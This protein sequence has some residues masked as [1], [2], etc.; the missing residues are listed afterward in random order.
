MAEVEASGRGRGGGGGGGGGGGEGEREG[1]EKTRKGGKPTPSM[2][3]GIA[4]AA[5]KQKQTTPETTIN[6]G[7]LPDLFE[8]VLE[9]SWVV[10]HKIVS[11]AQETG[12]NQE[13]EAG[14]R[15]RERERERKKARSVN[16]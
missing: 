15:E 14:E 11:K 13:R 3:A 16:S 6:N 7:V 2:H 1:E 9:R 4:L 12:H 10:V 5:G 8:L